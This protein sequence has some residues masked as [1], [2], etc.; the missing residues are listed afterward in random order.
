MCGEDIHHFV[1]AIESFYVNVQRIN[2]WG[3][4]SVK[5]IKEDSRI[6]DIGAEERQGAGGGG[7][8]V[9]GGEIPYLKNK[10]T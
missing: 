6:Q 10:Q 5:R 2:N 7:M 1:E 4:T 9:E 3:W 8:G